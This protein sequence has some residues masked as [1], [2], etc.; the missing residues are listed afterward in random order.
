MMQMSGSDSSTA[1]RATMAPE[2]GRQPKAVAVSRWINR[3]RF[4]RQTADGLF[5]GVMLAAVGEHRSSRRAL[6]H[7]IRIKLNL[8]S[9]CDAKSACCYTCCGPSQCCNTSCCGDN[10]CL[11]FGSAICQYCQYDTTWGGQS[12]W[13]NAHT[14]GNCTY[15]VTCCDCVSK[16]CIGEGN[17]KRCICNSTSKLCTGGTEWSRWDPLTQRWIPTSEDPLAEIV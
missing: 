2:A 13:Q 3:R 14:S 7:L 4:L 10:C 12:C 1:L 8:P 16:T 17:H 11:K 5:A 6:S 9:A 15:V